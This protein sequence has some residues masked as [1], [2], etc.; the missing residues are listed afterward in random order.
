VDAAGNES[1]PSNDGYLNVDLYP[2][3]TLKVVQ[4]DSAAPVVSW[5]HTGTNIDGYNLFLGANQETQLNAALLTATSYTDTAY[6]SNTRIYT[7]TAIDSNAV[8]SV[9]RSVTLPQLTAALSTD[10][11]LNRGI[12]NRLVPM[13]VGGFADLVDPSPMI[14]TLE[15]RPLTGEQIDIVRN[16]TIAVNEDAL[17]LRVETQELARNTAG[18][19][20]FTL[21]NTSDVEIEMW[22]TTC[23]LVVRARS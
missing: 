5:S 14:T 9:G 18:Q 8:E 20:R 10:S 12:M 7:V 11:S 21:T 15:V 6:T 4:Q 13:I 17:L 2:V 3:A 23:R 16:Q 19:V 1:L 22:S